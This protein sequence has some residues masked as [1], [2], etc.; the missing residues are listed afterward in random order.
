[1][2][3]DN[4]SINKEYSIMDSGVCLCDMD[5]VDSCDKKHTE[6]SIVI[7]DKSINGAIC[8]YSIDSGIA[9]EDKRKC[10]ICWDEDENLIRTCITFFSRTVIYNLG[11]GCKDPDLQYAHQH[12]IDQYM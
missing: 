12:C 7:D 1:M 4:L 9:N 6:T 8:R 3:S 2:L 11:Y 10:W 5:A